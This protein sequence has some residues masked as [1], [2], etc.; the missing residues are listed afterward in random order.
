MAQKWAVVGEALIT[1]QV[2]GDVE[3][4]DALGVE[5]M[6]GRHQ[7]IRIVKGADVKFDDRSQVATVALPGERRP[8]LASK[9]AAHARR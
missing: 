6:G 8:A 7:N 5:G 9:R 4:R 2:V 1:R 3:P